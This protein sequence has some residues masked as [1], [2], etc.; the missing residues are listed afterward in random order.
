MDLPSPI[1][2]KI[3]GMRDPDNVRAVASLSPHYLGFIFFSKSPRYVRQDFII[4]AELSQN[5]KRVGVFVNES[6]DVMVTQMHRQKL[7]YLQLHGNEG[8]QQCE[9]LKMMGAKI[10]KVFSVDD[11]FD[12]KTTHSYEAIAD[13]FLFDTKGKYYGG[14][15]ETFNWGILK[16]YNQK[17]PFFLSGGISPENVT[18]IVDLKDMNIHALDINSGV[19]SA[20][21]VKD[22][23]EIKKIIDIINSK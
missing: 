2:L 4:P 5:I 20:P 17:V 6:S 7:D 16:K 13:F 10:I 3:C 15:A 11:N 21:G 23:N 9:E 19:E 12:F 1:K 18:A 14:N 8:L 22:C